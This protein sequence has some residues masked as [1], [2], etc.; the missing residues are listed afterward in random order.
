MARYVQ[1]PP[2]PVEGAWGLTNDRRNQWVRPWVGNF[3]SL[4][5]LHAFQAMGQAPAPVPPA[6]ADCAT[7]GGGT[8]P[9]HPQGS[10]S[11]ADDVDLTYPMVEWPGSY[12]VGPVRNAQLSGPPVYLFAGYAAAIFAYCGILDRQHGGCLSNIAV[13]PRIEAVVERHIE[14]FVEVTAESRRRARDLINASRH[15]SWVRYHS[16]HCHLRFVVREDE[17]ALAASL[18]GQIDALLR[19]MRGEPTPPPAPALTLESLAAEVADLRGRMA[20]LEG[21]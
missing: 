9:G 14:G 11:G 3:L 15:E 10:H 16:D 17:E 12:H 7:E 19:E 4:A 18:Q 8:P 1:F 20:V 6:V 13:D 2:A 5:L 21:R